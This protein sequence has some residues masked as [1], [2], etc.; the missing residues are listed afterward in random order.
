[1]PPTTAQD[2][3]DA[4]AALVPDL[5]AGAGA[6]GAQEAAGPDLRTD[7]EVLNSI[8]AKLTVL[9]TALEQFG[10]MA[11]AMGDGMTPGALLKMLFGR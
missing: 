1:M 10:A 9:L 8:D 2:A 11:Q 7:R 6:G 3:P 5:V 4:P